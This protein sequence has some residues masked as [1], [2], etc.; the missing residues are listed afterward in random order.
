VKFW[1]GC[2]VGFPP[3]TSVHP[4][5]FGTSSSNNNMDVNTPSLNLLGSSQG[6]RVHLVMRAPLLP[7]HFAAK[8]CPCR[9]SLLGI[10]RSEWPW[11]TPESRTPLLVCHSVHASMLTVDS[12]VVS[13]LA[14][15]KGLEDRA[16]RLPVRVHVEL[17]WGRFNCQ[18][19]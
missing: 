5:F 12:L 6:W 11:P 10:V 7:F 16:A 4:P 14:L 19:P 2:S 8:H 3:Q 1:C 15:L 18:G 9:G 17:V 13:M